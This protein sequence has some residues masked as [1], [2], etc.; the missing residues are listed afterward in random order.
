MSCGGFPTTSSE[1]G[2]LAL[3]AEF[4][5]RLRDEGARAAPLQRVADEA[6]ACTAQ[7]EAIALP[8]RHYVFITHPGEL[9]QALRA[10]VPVP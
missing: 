9:A 3:E 5:A 1:L 2:T 4:R 7:R 10:R 6:R 8:G